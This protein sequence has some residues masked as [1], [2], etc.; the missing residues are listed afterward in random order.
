MEAWKPSDGTN[1][2]ELSGLF[3]GDIM[4]Y[5][6]QPNKNGLIDETYRWPNATIPYYID[7]AFSECD[8]IDF[9]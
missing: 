1:V 9:Y 2:W 3:E 7:E 5:T 8:Y 6:K 4:L